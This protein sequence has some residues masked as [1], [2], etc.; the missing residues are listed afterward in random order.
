LRRRRACERNGTTLH[1]RRERR[2]SN[3][4][5][6]MKILVCSDGSI[7]AWK[8]LDFAGILAK[9]TGAAVTILGLAEERTTAVPKTLQ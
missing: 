2:P 4:F 9:A 5:A 3:R 6:A 8:A 7:R 1:G